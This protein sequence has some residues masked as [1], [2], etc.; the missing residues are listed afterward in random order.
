MQIVAVMQAL[1]DYII[2]LHLSQYLIREKCQT[3]IGYDEMKEL[4]QTLGSTSDYKTLE[5]TAYHHVVALLRMN[6][7][8]QICYATKNL[9]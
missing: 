6:I 1:Y 4:I 7:A 3:K 9:V 2:I 8:V 5:M